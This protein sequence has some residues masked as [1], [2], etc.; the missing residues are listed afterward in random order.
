M[1]E[2]TARWNESWT[3]MMFRKAAREEAG[4]QPDFP[5]VSLTHIAVLNVVYFI[6]TTLLYRR[7]K[8]LL[9]SGAK[10]PVRRAE[11]QHAALTCVATRSWALR[12]CPRSSLSTM[13]S[14]WR[15]P[16]TSLSRLCATSCLWTLA[17]LRATRTLALIPNRFGTLLLTWRVRMSS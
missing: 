2:V 10:T 8:G 13:S 7:A 11:A 12:G 6:V 4:V 9:N 3:Q 5:Y 16:A 14:A 15:S 17:P 1:A